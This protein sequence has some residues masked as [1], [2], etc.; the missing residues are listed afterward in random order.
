MA[1]VCFIGCSTQ[2][3][4]TSEQAQ[5]TAGSSSGSDE[6]TSTGTQQW[7]YKVHSFKTPS[8]NIHCAAV[9]VGPKITN[10]EMRCFI[11]E[12]AGPL[13]PRPKSAH[14]DWDGGRSFGIGGTG[15]GSLA[16]F[17]DMLGRPTKP[18][19]LEYG[20]VW[21]YGPYTCLSSQLGLLC[22]NADGRGVFLSRERQLPF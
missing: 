6:T 7:D 13:L 10:A 16:S 12:I 21:A 3:D 19:T 8:G 9:V 1:A 15:A 2:G 17:C 11:K 18:L 22:T 14:C 4:Q 20:K 5:S